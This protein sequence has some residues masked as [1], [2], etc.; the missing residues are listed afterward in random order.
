MLSRDDLR[1]RRVGRELRVANVWLNTWGLG[2][3]Q[4]AGDPIKRS[5]YGSTA[6][7]RR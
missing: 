2:T 3:Q 7:P 4:M 5:G 6:E 1:A